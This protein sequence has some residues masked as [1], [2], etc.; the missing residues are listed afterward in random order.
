[1][2]FTSKKK[3]N[4]ALNCK[5]KTNTK[6][7]DNKKKAQQLM[8]SARKKKSAAYAQERMGRE[9]IKNKVKPG[10]MTAYWTTEMIGKKLPVGQERIDIAKRLRAEATRDS[11]NAVKLYPGIVKK[12]K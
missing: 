10:S 9:Q 8:E 6:M 7:P 4:F 12:K 1:M 5:S 11:L 2:W 3:C